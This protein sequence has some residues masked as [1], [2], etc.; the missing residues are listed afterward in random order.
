MGR[1][2]RL[3]KQHVEPLHLLHEE[4]DVVLRAGSLRVGAELSWPSAM[5]NPVWLSPADPELIAEIFESPLAA[6]ELYEE[7]IGLWSASEGDVVDKTMEFYTL[8]Y[9]QDNILTKVDRATMLTSLNPAPSSSTTTSSNS[10]G[11]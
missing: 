10:A 8:F 4:V 9:L 3:V 5:W 11:R 6:E 1:A 2:R 7:A